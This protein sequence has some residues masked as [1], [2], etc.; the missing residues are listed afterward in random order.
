MKV[1]ES[2]FYEKYSEVVNSFFGTILP[3]DSN[4]NAMKAAYDYCF[5]LYDSVEDFK[6]KTGYSDGE[7]N[8]C[9]ENG[10]ATDIGG[11]IVYFNEVNYDYETDLPIGEFSDKEIAEIKMIQSINQNQIFLDIDM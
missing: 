9:F 8:K 1:N 6:V 10:I 4:S 3:W 11:K 5:D 7:I 2:D